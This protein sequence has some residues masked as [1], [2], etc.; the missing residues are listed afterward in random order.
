MEYDFTKENIIFGYLIRIIKCD[1]L[2]RIIKCNMVQLKAVL[3]MKPRTLKHSKSISRASD[4][5][6]KVGG[7][8]GKRLHTY[9]SIYVYNLRKNTFVNVS[10]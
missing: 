3:S 4:E 1:I 2:I 7:G 6:R 5:I 10:A 9:I 8:G